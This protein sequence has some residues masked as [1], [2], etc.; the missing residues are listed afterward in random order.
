MVRGTGITRA[1]TRPRRARRRRRSRTA[2]GR[3]QATGTRIRQRDRLRGQHRAAE[4]AGERGPGRT[5]EGVQ[6][7][8]GGQ[9]IT[10]RGPQDQARHGRVGDACPRSGYG[11]PGHDLP[12]VR[13]E[14]DARAQTRP[15]RPLRQGPGQPGAEQR[16]DF[17]RD[18]RQDE[19][20]Q[21]GRQ[22]A[23]AADQDGGAEPVPG[24]RRRLHEVGGAD[25][26]GEKR[27]ADR[28][29]RD[30]GEQQRRARVDYHVNKW[31]GKP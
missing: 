30:V 31:R 18:R 16:G 12:Q 29:R 8:G 17:R 26:H 20:Q 22:Q 3:R 5:G 15:P 28:E 14:E 24:R 6:P 25:E 23:E 21:P 19:H 13:D 10:R 2:S 27:E 7:V 1:M 4:R 9:L 11:R